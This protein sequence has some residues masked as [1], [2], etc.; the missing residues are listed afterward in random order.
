VP[1]S[2]TVS[3]GSGGKVSVYNN[4]GSVHVI[5]DVVGYYASSTGPAGSRFHGV[6]PSRYFDTRF[7]TGGVPAQKI[8][9]DTSLKFN[10]LGKNGIPAS[11]V[12]GVVMNV[13]ATEA[14]AGTFV[15]VFP[16]DVSRPNASNLN[17]GP[18]QTVPNL[19][20]VRV[21]ASGIVDFYNNLGATHLIADV[22]GYYDGDKSTEAGR[23]V[24]LTPFRK[25]D[26]RTI[27]FKLPPNIG[28]I[29]RFPT[30]QG[31]PAAG[32]GSVVMN[33]T[34]TEPDAPSFLTVFPSDS[35]LPLASNLNFAPGQT[36]PNHVIAKVSTGPTP[37]GPT[38][39]GWIVFYNKAGNTH[40]IIDVFGY[41]TASFTD[42]NG[43]ELAATTPETTPAN[44]ANGGPEVLLSLGSNIP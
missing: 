23:F 40:L 19:V 39:T 32:I 5:L 16:D 37:G 2:V 7:G 33:V 44:A 11:G 4:Q 25:L 42:V 18:N 26:T 24:A 29:V 17:F 27:P 22:V 1:N 15:T 28:V 12:T 38:T 30:F 35:P 8:G 13:T 3:L 10:V 43:A 14:T 31:L 34:V 20:T 6:T 36:I 41:F 21:P 9:T